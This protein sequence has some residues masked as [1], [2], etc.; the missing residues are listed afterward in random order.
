[1]VR[2]E[3]LT[4]P[5]AVDGAHAVGVQVSVHR[6]TA[7]RNLT[8][9]PIRSTESCRDALP[10]LRRPARRLDLLTIEQILD[11]LVASAEPAVTLDSLAHAC[12]P[13][14]A[15]ECLVTVVDEQHSPP[16]PAHAGG[17]GITIDVREEP[18]A[19]AP[20]YAA[21]ISYRWHSER[22]DSADRVIARLLTEQAVAVIRQQRL[23]MALAQESDKSHH[24]A[25]ALATNRH[26]GQAI[27]I[28][29][30]TYKLTAEESFDLLR[31]VSQHSHRKLRDIADEVSQ[32]GTLP[33]LSG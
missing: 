33:A 10:A 3:S 23:S 2:N 29:M 25:Q 8:E 7:I 16:Q 9:R 32:T 28:L 14:F 22:V 12:V 26:I 27:G 17:C 20:G 19:G 13:A 15:D 31:G 24:L 1:L 4:A 5:S 11:Q 6:R 21:E 18:C 30:A